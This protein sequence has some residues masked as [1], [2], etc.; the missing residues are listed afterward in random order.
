[1]A[2]DL[3]VVSDL[4]KPRRRSTAPCDLLVPNGLS[5]SELERYVVQRYAAFARPGREV[6]RLDAEPLAA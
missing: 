2:L 6:R 4:G 5:G 1:M 3:A